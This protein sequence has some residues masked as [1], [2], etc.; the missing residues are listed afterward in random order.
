MLKER[1]MEETERQRPYRNWEKVT[2]RRNLE[3]ARGKDREGDI[4][5]KRIG[6]RE[7]NRE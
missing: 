1:Q 2:E 5:T 3:G 6:Q 7:G 4:K